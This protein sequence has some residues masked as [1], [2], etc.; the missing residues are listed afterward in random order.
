MTQECI[1]DPSEAEVPSGHLSQLSACTDGQVGAQRGAETGPSS[2]SQNS[3]LGTHNA[4][5]SHLRL[6]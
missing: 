2:H 3:R 4:M 1:S 5:G 6:F